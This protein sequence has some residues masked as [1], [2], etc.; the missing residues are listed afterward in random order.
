MNGKIINLIKEKDPD[1]CVF[2]YTDFHPHMLGNTNYAYVKKHM[3]SVI[4]IQE[5]KPFTKEPMSEEVS[6]GTYFFKSAELMIKAYSKIFDLNYSII[7]PSALYGER[8]VSRR[9]GQI[10]IENAIQNLN[11]TINGNGEEKL[12]F[13]YIKDAVNLVLKLDKVMLKFLRL[14][15]T[16]KSDTQKKDPNG[17]V[18]GPILCF[19]GPPGVGKTSLG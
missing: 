14:T 6:S 5:K 7:R 1:G 15:S 8:C 10:F 9:V 18:R 16:F 13:T 11:I 3:E 12:D 19:G 4:D 17:T 2:T